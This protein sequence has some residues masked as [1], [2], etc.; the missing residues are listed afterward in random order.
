MGVARQ[1]VAIR[2]N[3]TVVYFVQEELEVGTPIIRWGLTF[4]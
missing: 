2:D 1:G 4:G 3:A